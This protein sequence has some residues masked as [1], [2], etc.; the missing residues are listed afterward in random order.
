MLEVSQDAEARREK[1]LHLR[2]SRAHGRRC[3]KP[4]KD[5][6]PIKGNPKGKKGKDCKGDGKGKTGK[7]KDGKGKKNSATILQK[8]NKDASLD[9]NVQSTIEC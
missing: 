8:P 2:K 3:D 4:K 1:M 9:N 6:P 5:D 7:G